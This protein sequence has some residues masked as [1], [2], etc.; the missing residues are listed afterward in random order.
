[1]KRISKDD[2]KGSSLKAYMTIDQERVYDV[3]GEPHADKSWFVEFAN[4][5]RANVM[6]RTE[7]DDTLHIRGFEDAVVD[8]VSRALENGAEYS[9]EVVGE[10]TVR[11]DPIILCRDDTFNYIVTL[12]EIRKKYENIPSWIR[13]TTITMTCKIFS[14]DRIN[15]DL[16]RDYFH[17]HDGKVRIRRKGAL[18]D[19]HTWTMRDT[20]FYNQVTVGYEDKYSTKS[21]KVFPNG[22]FQ[23]AGCSDL[24]DCQRV[25]KQLAYLLKLCLSLDEPLTHD[26]FRVVMI[27][28]NFSMN[29]PINLMDVVDVLSLN[30]SMYVSFNPSSYSAVKIKFKPRPNMKQVTASVFS[31][32]KI[33]VTGAETL[34]EIV[35]AYDILNQELQ[36]FTY[37]CTP[38]LAMLEEKK[39]DTREFKELTIEAAKY[40]STDDITEMLDMG[41]ECEMLSVAEHVAKE[42]SKK[43]KTD[44]FDTVLGA[45]F[46]AWVTALKQREVSA[47]V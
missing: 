32:G 28:T 35:F 37:D 31:T 14:S 26:A 42:I 29:K 7:D 25:T 15:L 33:I 23:V 19:G 16:I 11:Q 24:Y 21:I 44:S 18:F 9:G 36:Q 46:D 3:F 27:N 41:E 2:L 38:F 13:I 10:S 1:M 20:T 30:K 45:K 17:R 4:G 34:K 22:S 6:Y 5:I 12:D 40:Y 8:E 43:K 39:T 47:W